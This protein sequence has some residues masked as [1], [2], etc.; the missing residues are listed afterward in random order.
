MSRPVGEIV[1]LV[2]ES[3]SG[4][5][6][7]YGATQPLRDAVESED[8]PIKALVWAFEYD[9]TQPDEA[10]RRATWGVWA[11][12]FEGNGVAYPPPLATV[13]DEHVALWAE[14]VASLDD[15]PI[16]AARLH[17][18]LWEKRWGDRP[19]LH[20]RAAIEGYLVVAGI[21]GEDLERAYVLLRALELARAIKDN[22]RISALISLIIPAIE[23]SL[24]ASEAQ[25]GVSLSFIEALLALPK[26]MQPPELDDLLSSARDVY[27]KDP[28][29]LQN[30][31]DLMATRTA[32]DSTQ[33]EYHSAQ[34]DAWRGKA[35]SATGVVKLTF[36]RRAQELAR[37]HGM[38]EEAKE[39]D[40][41]IQ[42][43][44]PSDL[45]LKEF[46]TTVSVPQ[47]VIDDAINRLLGA[48]WEESLTR[49]GAIGPPSGDYDKN[50]VQVEQSMKN[51]PLQYLFSKT[52]I[53]PFN[54]P[55]KEIAGEAQHRDQALIQ[56]EV[57]SISVEAH[58]RADALD[59][60]CER[61]G[62][63]AHEDLAK[64]FETPLIPRDVADRVAR[65]L[66]L[67]REG[68]F[69]ESAHVLLPRIEAILRNIVRSMNMT[70]VR[71]PRGESPG[72]VRL[73][74]E[75]INSLT[76]RLD[77]SWRR[78][79]RTALIEPT[80]LNL[81]N[82]LLHGLVP[83]AERAQAAILIQIAAYLRL[84]RIGDPTPASENKHPEQG[85]EPP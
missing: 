11:P 39:I 52:I 46:S 33:N 76:G 9:L 72:G 3:L 23:T 18:L 10:D 58:I 26:A 54:M 45:D 28:W 80:G 20:A 32:D 22:D 53:G 8:D 29:I 56:Q 14:V 60:M 37:L 81:R 74:G 64:L 30:V 34:V 68:S 55:I 21:V 41:E 61:H 7:L 69:D 62:D 35:E 50:L 75:L 15:I 43:L 1:R 31:L 5:T 40:L 71:P 66:E 59:R 2:R 12:W 51:F 84:V 70:I 77:E 48:D 85:V 27:S 16:P 13:A 78:Y 67:Y 44:S 79:L 25:P 19:D 4:A 38:N 24:A 57:F 17:D 73:L 65:A 83:S 63:V 42:S 47:E 36:L 6:A 49:F 82:S